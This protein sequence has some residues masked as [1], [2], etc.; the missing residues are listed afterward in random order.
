MLEKCVIIVKTI[1]NIKKCIN[2]IFKTVSEALFPDFFDHLA[3]FD[4]KM[5]EVTVPEEETVVPVEPHA[6][7]PPKN[8]NTVVRWAKLRESE[9][10]ELAEN[11][12]SKS[13]GSQTRWAVSAFKGLF[14][15][16]FT[17]SICPYLMIYTHICHFSSVF[18][19][20]LMVSCFR[21]GDSE[22]NR[23]EQCL[24][25]HNVPFER[26]STILG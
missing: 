8:D 3:D 18:L 9:L 12:H 7:P 22:S 20:F 5:P 21:R 24:H 23:H 15:T 13:T 11:R 10:N 16:L 2:A 26:F 4:E 1:K 6:P 17:W 25:I 14:L 19:P